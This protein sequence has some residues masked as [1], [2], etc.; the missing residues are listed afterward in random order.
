MY[1]NDGKG[2]FHDDTFPVRASGGETRYISWGIGIED[3]D[4]D[5][6]P[7]VFW[8]TGGI[9]PELQG[10]PDHNAPRTAYRLPAASGNGRLLSRL[11]ARL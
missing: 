9:Y 3:L 7:D 10:R 5:G 2:E 6:N 4:N 8:V 1:T 11:T